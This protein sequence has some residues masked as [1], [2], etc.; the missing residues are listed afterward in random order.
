M[1]HPEQIAQMAVVLWLR[2]YHPEILFTS[3]AA[4]GER[5]SLQKAIRVKRMGY[6]S[7]TSDLLIFE[8]RQG[9]HGFAL[10]M[11]RAKGGTTSPEQKAFL[12]AMQERGYKTAVCHG[13]QEAVD[14]ITEYMEGA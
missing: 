2:R 11:K 4:A 1:K 3:P 8:P 13:A 5:L 9:F 14:A 7:G 6:L 10:E 12:K